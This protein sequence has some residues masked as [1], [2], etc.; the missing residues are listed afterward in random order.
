MVDWLKI[1]NQTDDSASLYFYG[2][3]VSSWWGAWDD[4]DQY[5]ENVRKVLDEVKGK[6]LNIYIN[7]GGGSVFAGMAIY[8]MIKRHQGM[9]T[10][11]VDGLAGSIASIIALAGDKLIVPSNAYLMIHKPWSGAYGNAKEL[12]KMAEDL[13]AI[14]EGIINVYKENLK[15]GVDIEVI[16]EMVQNE[17]WLNGLKASE[18]FDIEVAEENTAV[19]C[20]SECFKD[21]KNTPQAFTKQRE[22]P[23]SNDEQEKLNK[24]RMEL[25]L[26]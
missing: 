9:K 8:N 3:I 23:P 12:R 20:V 24:L 15:D 14:E 11:H 16:R 6:N 13:D 21:Y 2:D 17:T 26:I 5:P 22:V 18:Y 4:E 1:K 7:S 19:A 25:D 10:V